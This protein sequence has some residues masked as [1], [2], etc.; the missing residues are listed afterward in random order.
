MVKVS[1]SLAGRL[2]L[3]ELTPFLWQEV[4]LK[5]HKH[6]WLCGGYPDGGVLDSTQF[7]LWQDGYLS[8]LA[9]RDLPNWGLAAKPQ[10]AERFLKMVAAV[11]GQAWNAASS[12]SNGAG[13]EDLTTYL[14][15]LVGVFLVR[16]GCFPIRRI[17][18]NVW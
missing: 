1:Q 16:K 5:H 17:S 6:L 9:R 11:H 10:T 7:P 15:Y 14:D 18:K 8:L 3:L 2:A 4:P 13:R 12:A